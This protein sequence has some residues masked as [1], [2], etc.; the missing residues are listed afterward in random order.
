MLHQTGASFET[1][2]AAAPQDEAKLS[3]AEA[4]ILHPEVRTPDLIRGKPRRTH[5]IYAIALAPLFLAPSLA[6]ACNCGQ[7]TEGDVVKTSVAIVRGEVTA[8]RLTDTSGP[9]RGQR[10]ATIRV[11]MREKGEANELIEVVTNNS[12]STCGVPFVVGDQVRQG[13]LRAGT[14]WSTTVCLSLKA[15]P[16][17]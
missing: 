3:I 9:F 8:V 13:L 16:M 4:D 12:P 10:I 11:T 7:K 14:G 17:R 15:R 1:P 2:P 5:T 6:H